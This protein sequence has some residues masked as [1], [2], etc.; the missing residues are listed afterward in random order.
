MEKLKLG[1]FS[2]IRQ[3]A[4]YSKDFLSTAY[5]NVHFA[6]ITVKISK[7]LRDYKKETWRKFFK[8]LAMIMFFSS[9]LFVCGI[10]SSFSISYDLVFVSVAFLVLFSALMGRIIFQSFK[11]LNL[12]TR[13]PLLLGYHGA[14]HKVIA[15]YEETKRYDITTAKQYS[16]VHRL[17]GTRLDGFLFVLSLVNLLVIL[18]GSYWSWGYWLWVVVWLI[19]LGIY[20][21]SFLSWP[22]MHLIEFIGKYTQ[23]FFTVREPLLEELLT[24][25]CALLGLLKA[26]GEDVDMPQGVVLEDK[27]REN[28]AFK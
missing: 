23:R 11:E 2:N 21:P 5:Y 1:G 17:C 28:L 9:L 24:A 10:F 15:S 16:P 12:R 4:I 8:E 3:V 20:S 27:R 18:I 14:E 13:W 7:R 6:E 26:H 19:V 22:S 25:H